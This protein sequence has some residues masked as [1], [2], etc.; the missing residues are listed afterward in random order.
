MGSC[1]NMNITTFDNYKKCLD[2]KKSI[3]VENTGMRYIY[4]KYV[5]IHKQK[6]YNKRHLKEDRITTYPLLECE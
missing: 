2:T 3:E 1:N 6:Q 5:G 4:M